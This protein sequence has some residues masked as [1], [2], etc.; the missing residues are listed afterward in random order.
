[1]WIPRA[2]LFDANKLQCTE[3]LGGAFPAWDLASA[4]DKIELDLPQ[5]VTGATTVMKALSRLMAT[6]LPEL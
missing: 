1:V 3:S 5:P 6:S 4:Q 2:K